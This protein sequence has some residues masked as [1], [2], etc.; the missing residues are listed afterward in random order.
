MSAPMLQER[1]ERLKAC[2][3]CRDVVELLREHDVK[4]YRENCSHCPLAVFLKQAPDCVAATMEPGWLSA[5]PA[6]GP[7]RGEPHKIPTSDG[8]LRVFVNSFDDGEFPEL[9]EENA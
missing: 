8:P 4:G 9:E 7:P 5:W 3:T 2:V 1:L 6:G